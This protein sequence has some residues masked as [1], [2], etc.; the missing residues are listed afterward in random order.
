MARKAAPKIDKHAVLG[1]LL[2]NYGLEVITAKDFEAQMTHYGFTQKDVDEWCAE[3][4]RRSEH[5]REKDRPARAA[6][7][8]HAG[9]QR[10][11]GH[12]GVKVRKGEG[13]G[14]RQ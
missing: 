1:G 13:E 3:N 2:M 9:G 10:G 6:V 5:E 12:S 11:E 8:G 14:H 4:H 7:A